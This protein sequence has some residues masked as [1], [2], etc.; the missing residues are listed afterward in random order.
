MVDVRSMADE[1]G[2]ARGSV[3]IGFARSVGFD[4][5]V[6]KPLSSSIE[7]S[8]DDSLEDLSGALF[9]TA[10][11]SRGA[12]R[13]TRYVRPGPQAHVHSVWKA[14]SSHGQGLR[15]IRAAKL[16]AALARHG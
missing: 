8:L 11:L 10:L 3:G 1:T 6:V 16:L 14:G 12:T 13:L 7:V 15:L 2:R 9:S 5:M 4:A